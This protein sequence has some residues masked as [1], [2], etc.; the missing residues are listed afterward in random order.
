MPIKQ[1]VEKRNELDAN[2]KKLKGIF[3]EGGRE[4]KTREIDLSKIKSISGDDSAKLNDIRKLKEYIDALGKEVGELAKMEQELDAVELD[5]K[6]LPGDTAE[7][8]RFDNSMGER[9]ENVGFGDMFVNSDLYKNWRNQRGLKSSVDLKA[10]AGGPLLKTVF[11]TSAGWSP[12]STRIGKLVD[13]AQRPVE[14]IDIIPGGQTQQAVV[15]YMEETT[16]T[17]AA[18]FRAEAAAYAE[19]T[20]ALTERSVTCRSIGAS[21]PVTDEQMEDEPMVRSYLNA[22]MPFTVRQQLDQMILTASGVAPEWTGINNEGS[23]Q[24]QARGTDPVPDA[25]YK[26]MDLVQFTG[27]AN[28]SNIV[29]HPN[30]WQAVRLLRTSDGIYIWGNP[31]QS[32]PLTLWGLPVLVTTAQTQNTGLVGDFRMFCQYFVRRDMAVEM[33]YVNDDFLDGRITIRAGIRGAF[34]TYRDEAFCQVTG[35]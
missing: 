14:V 7:T 6:R 1:L 23:V 25:F 30:D 11:Q 20:F 3:E 8:K 31:S 26:A 35:I 28:A 29:I 2:T 22:R 13:D 15:V 16:L 10:S 27:R 21:L 5:E 12:E 9:D 4:G 17:N 24:T 33:G 19:N 32:G 18:D 34:V